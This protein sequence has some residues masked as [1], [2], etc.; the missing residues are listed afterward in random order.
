MGFE[1]EMTGRRF[2]GERAGPASAIVEHIP[3][4]RSDLEKNLPYPVSWDQKYSAT[5][6]IVRAMHVYHLTELE[7]LWRDENGVYVT[8]DGALKLNEG[9]GSI[10]R[11]DTL[12]HVLEP[13]ATILALMSNH[14]KMLERAENGTLWDGYIG[15]K[16]PSHKKAK[17]HHLILCPTYIQSFVRPLWS[18]HIPS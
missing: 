7:K 12:E 3:I 9:S 18:W 17:I 5:R 10:L 4:V 8:E 11:A 13:Y 6:D 14:K 16:M 15:G 1:D 2:I